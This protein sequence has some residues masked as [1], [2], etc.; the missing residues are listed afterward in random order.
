MH[1]SQRVE[2][3]GNIV[4]YDPSAFRNSLQLS[5][6]RRFDDIEGT[7]KYKA[8]QKRFPCERHG[9]QSYQ[10][11]GDLINHHNL[12]IFCPRASCYLRSRGN[13]DQRDQHGQGDRNRCPQRGRKRVG[14]RR[15]QQ[16]GCR[17]SPGPR[18]RPQP[19]D[20]EK[21]GDQRSPQRSSAR[22]PRNSRRDTGTTLAFQRGF[23]DSSPRSSGVLS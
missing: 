20:T 6:R 18:P 17:R 8:R 14:Q 2:T 7:K 21:R 23:H 4:Q 3:G 16:H 11:T 15:P 13:A 1:G 9:D 19:P 5:H 22:R 12:R 10:L